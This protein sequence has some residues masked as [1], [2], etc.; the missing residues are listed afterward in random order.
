M[1]PPNNPTSSLIQLL[2][3]LSYISPLSLNNRKVTALALFQPLL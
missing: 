2:N 3:Y 1:A